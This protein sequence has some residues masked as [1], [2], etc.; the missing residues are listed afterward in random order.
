MARTRRLTARIFFWKNTVNTAM[1]GMIAIR[2]SAS[3]QFTA[4]I[5]KTQPTTYAALQKMSTR[6]QAS[7]EPILFVSLITRA[8][9]APP[10]VVS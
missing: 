7:T 10:G 9:T 5:T 3:R 4:S 8:M 2:I 6:L 1:T